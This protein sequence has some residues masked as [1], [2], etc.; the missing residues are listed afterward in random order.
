[1]QPLVAVYND[2]VFV[3][4]VDHR[5]YCSRQTDITDWA[6]GADMGD[7]GRP[8]AGQLSIAGM[9]G[10]TPTA[11]I[12]VD[13]RFMVFTCKNSIWVLHG[14]P[15]TGRLQQVTPNVGVISPN[16]WAKTPDDTM[17]FLSNDGIYVWKIG[18][19]SEPVR[20]SDER[21]PEELKNVDESANKINMEYDPVGK[22]IHLFITPDTGTGSHYWIDLENK[23]IWPVLLYADHQPTALSRVDDGTDLSKVV[24]GC[25]DGYLRVFDNDNTDDDGVD[26]TSHV[27]V[28]PF[29]IAGDDMHDAMLAEIHGIMATMPNA[30]KVNWSVILGSSAEDATD[31]AVKCI[32]DYIAGSPIS[33]VSDYGVWASGRNKVVRTR[34]RG[35]WCVIWLNSTDAWSFENISITSRQLGRL[36]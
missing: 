29:R 2:R 3:S 8:V 24:I 9:H 28:G 19:S 1:L 6:F 23:A 35:A 10:E 11:L 31:R 36:R 4:G 7:V 14:D 12:P 16:A 13:N 30:S 18:S 17:L 33:G 15:A 5:W 20:F 27:L 25:R 21:I 22:G 34:S 32:D 26:L